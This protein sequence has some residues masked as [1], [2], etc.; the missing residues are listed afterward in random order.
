MTNL[1]VGLELLFVGMVFVF[2]VLLLLMGISILMSKLIHNAPQR[3]TG[4]LRV[5]EGELD[6]EELAAVIAV[7]S[8]LIEYIGPYQV[9]ISAAK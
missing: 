4:Q 8:P 5:Q 9:T 3:S 6:E 1:Q 7:V 2:F